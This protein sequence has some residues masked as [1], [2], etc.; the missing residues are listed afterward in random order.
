M[1]KLPASASL[2]YLAALG[3]AAGAAN[4]LRMSYDEDFRNYRL[5]TFPGAIETTLDTACLVTGGYSAL[6]QGFSM[7]R[8]AIN[9]G[10]ATVEIA[11]TATPIFETGVNITPRSVAVTYRTIGKGGRT[12]VTTKEAVQP[13]TGPLEGGRIIIRRAQAQALE[14][15]LGLVPNSLERI[16]L[17]SVIDNISVRAAASPLTGNARFL[18]GS[19]GL[20][21]GGPELT[22]SG[23][24]SS[25][26]AGI[27][28]IILEIIEG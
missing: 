10:R 7:L 5:G 27:T 18:G 19:V 22:I 2:P 21:G 11:S 8:T 17:I 20:P 23:A 15:A 6:S 13:F 24:P 12:F 1:W 26:G 9:S 25:G 4:I 3:V 14:D 16:N 28:Q